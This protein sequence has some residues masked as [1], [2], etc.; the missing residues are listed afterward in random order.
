MWLS[1]NGS[2]GRIGGSV[3]WELADAVRFVEF[4]ADWPIIRVRLVNT[5]L[6]A[7]WGRGERILS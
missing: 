5:G 1:V 3:C 6:R 2:Y 7:S 4:Q